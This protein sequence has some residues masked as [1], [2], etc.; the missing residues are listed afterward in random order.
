MPGVPADWFEAAGSAEDTFVR[1]LLGPVF[2][3]FAVA[4]LAGDPFYAAAP[5][6]ISTVPPP[7][8]SAWTST[9]RSLLNLPDT[10]FLVSGLLC[11]RIHCLIVDPSPLLAIAGLGAL[12]PVIW[13][14]L[15][16][17]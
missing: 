1:L 13:A 5:L 7:G 17:V 16:A 11:L 15:R 3:L 4:G 14:T 8:A 2:G 9:P 10:P 12:S 6:L